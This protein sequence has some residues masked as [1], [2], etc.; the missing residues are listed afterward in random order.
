MKLTV[1]KP[2]IVDLYAVALNLTEEEQRQFL[3]ATGFATYDPE[4]CARIT[5]SYRGVEYVMVTADGSPVCA[6]GA[7]EVAAGV[8]QTWMLNTPKAFGEHAREVTRNVRKAMR[9]FLEIDGCRRL[10]TYS[11]TWRT[12][13]LEWYVQGLG[14]TREGVKRRFYRD[15]DAVEFSLVNEEA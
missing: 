10:Q 15:G 7:Y 4:E 12:E 13:A 5:A 14:M 8:F 3:A 9:A 11:S 6:F 1:L 2:S